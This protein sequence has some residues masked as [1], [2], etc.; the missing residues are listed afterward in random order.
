MMSIT[1][2]QR[3]ASQSERARLCR[4]KAIECQHIALTTTDPNIRVRCFHL[5][6]LWREMADDAEQRTN[7]ASLSK[8]HS[9][10]LS[11]SH[12]QKV[13]KR[14]AVPRKHDSD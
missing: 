2:W 14:A 13:R 4:R 7:G 5:A 10:V 8:Q 1:H 12:F 6:K 9:V 3:S 11:L